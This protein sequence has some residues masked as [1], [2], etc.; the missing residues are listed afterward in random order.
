MGR[1]FCLG[2]SRVRPPRFGGR[3]VGG[4]EVGWKIRAEGWFN[5]S[6]RARSNGETPGRVR[7][8]SA[9]RVS[10]RGGR[11]RPL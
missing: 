2:E 8:G 6:G 9:A 10:G 7:L 1:E 4:G 5:P 11:L 3:C